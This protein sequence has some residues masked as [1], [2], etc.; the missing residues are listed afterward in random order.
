[1]D[2][3]R[4]S[5]RQR[6]VI[7]Y[8]KLAK[9]LEAFDLDDDSKSSEDNDITFVPLN[10]HNVQETSTP[11]LRSDS[12]LHSQEDSQA[13]TSVSKTYTTTSLNKFELSVVLIDSVSIQFK[14]RQ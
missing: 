1:M 14:N 8:K 12:S 10:D 4:K 11:L 3:P 5:G 13:S 2:T 9:G 7:D 6:K